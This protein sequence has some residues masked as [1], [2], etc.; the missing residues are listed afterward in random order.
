MFI[1]GEAGKE[2]VLPLENNT[3]W[4]TQIANMLSSRLSATTT[5]IL[6]VSEKVFGEIAV[7]SINGIT[8]ATGE[9]PLV[10]A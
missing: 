7:S 2:A 10:I 6:K 9:L 5:V 4:I 1:A 3:E 8:R